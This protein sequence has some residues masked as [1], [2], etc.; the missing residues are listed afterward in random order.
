MIAQ[1]QSFLDKVFFDQD[2][3]SVVLMGGN[4]HFHREATG[5][6]VYL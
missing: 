2:F 4:F 1:I 3:L 6:G 5:E